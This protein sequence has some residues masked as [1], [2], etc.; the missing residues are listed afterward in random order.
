MDPHRTALR[1]VFGLRD[2]GCLPCLDDIVDEQTRRATAELLEDGRYIA[3]LCVGLPKGRRVHRL[4]L[5]VAGLQ[6]MNLRA[7]ETELERLR[8]LHDGLQ[9]LGSDEAWWCVPWTIGEL[10]EQ[11]GTLRWKRDAFARRL[12]TVAL[13]PLFQP[14]RSDPTGVYGQTYATCTPSHKTGFVTE[15]TFLSLPSFP[16]RRRSPTRLLPRPDTWW[17]RQGKTSITVGFGE[18]IRV[19]LKPI[20]GPRALAWL[21]ENPGKQAQSLD[22]QAIGTGY[23]PFVYTDEA[24]EQ[25]QNL[26]DGNDRSLEP[27]ELARL[28]ALQRRLLLLRDIARV[29]KRQPKWGA[30]PSDRADALEIEIADRVSRGYA[31]PAEL[32]EVKN[33][34]TAV[35]R[36]LRDV[37]AA[38]DELTSLQPLVDTGCESLYLPDLPD[39]P[40]GAIEA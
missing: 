21:L 28:Q 2:R 36:A 27:A 39:L 7:C 37:F 17:C 22:L 8:E 6:V 12:T 24:T 1:T 11:L 20:M 14:H 26:L 3:R 30:N 15:V 34:T 33:A 31:I 5:T 38:A 9:W 29:D 13:A 16:K 40:D 32:A 19:Q 18:K 10:H 4:G 35:T 25:V 23:D